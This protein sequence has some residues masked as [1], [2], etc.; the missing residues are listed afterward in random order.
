MVLLVDAMVSGASGPDGGEEHGHGV[1]SR[2]DGVDDRDDRAG[3]HEVAAR[4]MR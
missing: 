1:S 2:R 4:V 3:D